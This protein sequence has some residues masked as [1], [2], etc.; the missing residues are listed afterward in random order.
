MKQYTT[1]GVLG[2]FIIT[3]LLKYNHSTQDKL[4]KVAIEHQLTERQ[5]IKLFRAYD[6][7]PQMNWDEYVKEVKGAKQVE[8]PREVLPEPL[9]A[10]VEQLEPLFFESRIG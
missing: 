7:N 2:E 9:K 8:I 3:A 1:G 6:E 5:S 10:E 4:A